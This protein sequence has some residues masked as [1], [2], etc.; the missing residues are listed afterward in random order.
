[1]P[2]GKDYHKA[3]ARQATPT[4]IEQITLALIN[5]A[6][7][8]D[9]K[10]AQL[11]FDR[12]LGKGADRSLFDVLKAQAIFNPPPLKTAEDLLAATEIVATAVGRGEIDDQRAN[13][14]L[15]LIEA[16]RRNIETVTLAE[17]LDRLEALLTSGA[18][19]AQSEGGKLEA[20]MQAMQVATSNGHP[21]GLLGDGIEGGDE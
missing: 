14:L 15:G 3:V 13:R 1:M 7:D 8:G 6:K 11:I 4:D 12:C 16:Q 18:A 2:K 20:R 9:P 10:S 21:A 5:Q 19:A 17:R